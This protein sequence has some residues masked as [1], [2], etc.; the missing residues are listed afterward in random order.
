MSEDTFNITYV[1][2]MA[3]SYKPEIFFNVFKRL[4][5]QFAN[6]K[7]RFNFIGNAPW[8]LR[9]MVDDM[10]MEANCSWGGHIGHDEAVKEMQKAHALLLIIPDTE[11][12]KGILTGKLFEY[13]GA[14]RI[15]IGIGP[16]EGD[17]AAIIRE[18][19]AGEMFERNQEDKLFAWMKEKVVMWKS[20]DEFKAG[21]NFVKN[22]TREALT[23]RLSL[24]LLDSK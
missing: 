3:D 5:D 21:N 1:G 14:K 23:K 12:A 9:K 10:G 18:C 4:V 15:I 8:T 11:G 2:T 20:G 22:Y 17:A 19:E 6:L 7:I 24:I 16:A 13:L